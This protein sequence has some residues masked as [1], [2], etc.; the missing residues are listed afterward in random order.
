MA[1]IATIRLVALSTVLVFSLIALGLAAAFTAT[2]ITFLDVYFT[3]AAL[4]IATAGLTMLTIPAMIGLEIV[5]PGGPTSMIIV[6]ISWLA[7]LSILWL[8]TGAETAQFTA[9]WFGCGD[10]IAFGDDDGID[11]ATCH[12]VSGIEAFAFLNWLILMGYTGMLLVMSLVAASRKHSNVWTSSVANVPF[13][14]PAPASSVPGSYVGHAES[15]NVGG[16]NTS[17]SIQGGTVHV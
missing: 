4:A 17:N 8:S 16:Y 1:P 11:L 5:R 9:V 6:E 7:F 2:S 3:Y 13:N 15:P 14:A 12:E 10:A